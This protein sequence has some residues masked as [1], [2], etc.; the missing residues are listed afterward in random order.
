MEILYFAVIPARRESIGFRSLGIP[1]CAGM[2]ANWCFST[3]S[4]GEKELT[5]LGDCFACACNIPELATLA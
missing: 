1:A 5:T 2:T 4:K 3:P